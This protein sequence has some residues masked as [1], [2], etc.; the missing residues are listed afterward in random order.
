MA[1]GGAGAVSRRI[2]VLSA[3][4]DFPGRV[5]QVRNGRRGSLGGGV[6]RE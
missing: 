3:G 2:C 1:P 4:D 6:N 5:G